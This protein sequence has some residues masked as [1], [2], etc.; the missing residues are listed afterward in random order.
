MI[1]RNGIEVDMCWLLLDVNHLDYATLLKKLRSAHEGRGPK[2]S[3]NISHDGAQALVKLMGEM[4]A[5]TVGEESCIL[6]VFTEVDHDQAIDLVSTRGTA[7][8]PSAGWRRPL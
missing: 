7:Q 3:V 1:T 4:P 8:D 6:R 5:V 2:L